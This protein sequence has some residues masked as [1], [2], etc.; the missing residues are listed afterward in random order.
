MKSVNFDKL[1]IEKINNYRFDYFSF[2]LTRLCP[3]CRPKNKKV[4]FQW[5]LKD[6]TKI[7]L[8]EN[9]FKWE[10]NDVF[11]EFSGS[12]NLDIMFFY[13]FEVYL[14]MSC[15]S[16]WSNLKWLPP[17]SKRSGVVPKGKGLV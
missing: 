12:E 13:Q 16:Y 17:L 5:H 3:I 8:L 1:F 4:Q 15:W 9:V 10:N 6:N 2:I 11:M 14:G 7:I